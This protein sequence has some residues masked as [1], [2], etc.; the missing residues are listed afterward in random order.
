MPA[1]LKV[2]SVPNGRTF[3]LTPP[4][5]I[6]GR[7]SECGITL[8]AD[9]DGYTMVG[10]DHDGK[11]STVTL[12]RRHAEFACVNGRW[13][14]ADLGSMNGTTVNSKRIGQNEAYLADGDNVGLGSVSL[15]F[16]LVPDEKGPQ[17]VNEPA[18]SPA[19]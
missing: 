9:K 18:V 13:T 2:L 10:G 3:V 16:N 4:K 1:T 17:T 7:S 6:I 11:N 15:L 5:Q 12:S 14:V 19:E 8:E